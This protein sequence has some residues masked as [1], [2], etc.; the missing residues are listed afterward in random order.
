[1]KTEEETLDQTMYQARKRGLRAYFDDYPLYPGCW[2]SVACIGAAA[3]ARRIYEPLG[4][5]RIQ[6]LSDWEF[7]VIP[8][9]VNLVFDGAKRR[10]KKRR[11]P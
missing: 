4:G 11:E 5:H 7:T 9:A 8:F 3:V 10:K 1:M 6:W 2:E